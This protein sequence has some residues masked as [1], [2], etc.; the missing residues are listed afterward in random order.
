M[1]HKSKRIREIAKL[2]DPEKVYSIEEAIEIL[3][4]CPPVKF[5]QSLDIAIKTS[6]DAR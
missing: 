5:D 3:K 2:V 1:T 6:V 4:K